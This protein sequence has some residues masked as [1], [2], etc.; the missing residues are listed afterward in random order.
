MGEQKVIPVSNKEQRSEFTHHL[1]DDVN[2]L[3]AMLQNDLIESGV[4]RIGLEQEFCLVDESWRPS[5]ASGEILASIDDPHFTTE[6]ARYNLEINL[7]PLVLEGACFTKMQEQLESLLEKAHRAADK[8][9]NKVI[10]TGILPTISKNE[11][12]MD[13]MTPAERYYTLN[14][15]IKQLKGGDFRLHIRGVDELSLKHDNILFEAC[16]TSFQLHLQVD[17]SDFIS[18]FNWAQAISGPVLGIC[19][20]SPLLLGKEL[21]SETRIALFQQSVDMRSSAYALKDQ[22]PRVAFGRDWAKGSIADIYK[23]DIALYE[24]LIARDIA[25][26][27]TEVLEN[28]GIPKL[29]ALML[30]N[31]TVYRWNRPC[32]GVSDGKAH[33]RIENRYIPSGPTPLDEM[34]NFAFWVG[35][36]K[37]RP[38]RYDHI[39]EVMNFREAKGNFIKAA[40]TGKN[41]V[42]TWMGIPVSVRDMVLD[43]LLPIAHNGLEKMGVDSKDRFK[44]L[45]IIEE[46]AKSSTGSQW[47][48]RNYRSLRSFMKA[49]R[50][51]VHLTRAMHTNERSGKPVHKWPEIERINPNKDN[52]YLVEHIMSTLL[53]TVNEHDLA[54]LATSIMSWKDIH[55]LPV[56]NNDHK[57]VGLLTWTH[58]KKFGTTTRTDQ[59]LVSDIMT[60]DV[61][62]IS[63]DATIR[64][65]ISIM[66]E[67]EIGCLPVVHKDSLIGII[68]IKDVIEFDNE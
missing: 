47:I 31:G 39:S 57:L 25:Y 52:T 56:K 35:L 3:E 26:N 40:R 13:Y 65:A 12:N 61:I 22:Q 63:P 21:W 42:L 27:S 37:G 15:M 53:F 46:R 62:T 59:S 19:A 32:Y 9:N 58:M 8:Y 18:S 16:N 2:A 33:I 6:L 64:E 36:M 14:D 48:R 38:A 5:K 68:T 43:E 30:H 23:N 66:K 67:N 7:D 55:H 49:D 45:G 29:P 24:L 4:S 50:T 11:L 34:A 1:I 51:L 10:L 41:T 60:K 28:G 20:N 44:L 17:P 54:K